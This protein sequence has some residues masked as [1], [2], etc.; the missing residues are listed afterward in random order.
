[1]VSIN[2]VEVGLQQTIKRQSLR[3]SVA[4]G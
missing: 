4:T 1:V 3:R 2:V